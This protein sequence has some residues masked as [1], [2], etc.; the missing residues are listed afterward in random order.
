MKRALPENAKMSKDAK[1]CVQECVSEFIAFITSEA[2]ERLETDKRKT[3]TGDDGIVF[4]F[5]F[6]CTF[7]MF[8]FGVHETPWI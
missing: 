5:S 2:S 8:S 6:T 1:T 4:L 3:I 7:L